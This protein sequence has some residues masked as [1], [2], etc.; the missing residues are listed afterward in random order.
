MAQQGQQAP[1]IG[2]EL[3][4]DWDVTAVTGEAVPSSAVSENQRTS[5][6]VLETYGLFR[7][8]NPGTIFFCRINPATGRCF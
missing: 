2:I 4:D 1:F 8:T 5:A 7:T 3:S 6:E